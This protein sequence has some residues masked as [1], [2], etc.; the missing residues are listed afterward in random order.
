VNIPANSCAAFYGVE[1]TYKL[2]QMNGIS[3]VSSPNA[4]MRMDNN[5]L[6]I[7]GDLPS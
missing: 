5:F 7:Q 2:Y 4:P 3:L 6:T 1:T